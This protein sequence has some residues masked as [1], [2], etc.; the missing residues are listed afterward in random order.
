[1]NAEI[2]GLRKSVA[3][4]HMRRADLRD[5]TIL[6][7]LCRRVFERPAETAFTFV[8]DSGDEI[9]LSFA[10]L[11]ARVRRIAA[12]V[13]ELSVGAGRVLLL[14]P[15]GLEAVVAFFAAMYAKAV[16]VPAN[17]PRHARLTDRITRIAADATPGAVLTTGAIL[18]RTTPTVEP[19]TLLAGVPW[20]ATDR[21]SVSGDESLPL[22][23]VPPD[24]LAF[25]QYTSG[26]ISEPMGVM[27]RH[28]NLM[29]DQALAESASPSDGRLVMASWLPY[30]HDMGLNA[31]LRTIFTGGSAVLM[32]PAT[33]MRR[34]AR[35]LKTI[36]KFGA[37]ESGGPNF[38]FDLC[39]ETIEPD[40]MAG[41]DLSRWKTAWVGAEPVR[42]ETLMNFARH[43]LPYGFSESSFLPSYGLAEATV[44]ATGSGR[45]APRYVTVDA[46]ALSENVVRPP[47]PETRRRTVFVS[48][49]AANRAGGRVLI[50]DPSTCAPKLKNVV[51][52][53]W[54][55]GPHVAQGYWNRP[56]LS[57]KTFRARA[58]D[59][60]AGDYLRTGD[61]GFLTDDEEL[62]VTGRLK[63]L[64]IV[65]G[66]NHY[67]QDIELTAECCSSVLRKGSSAAF[68]VT[69]GG[70]ELLV[71]AIEIER[72]EMKNVDFDALGRRIANAVVRQHEV[73]VH[74]IVFLASFTIPKTSSGKIQRSATRRAYEKAELKTI[75]TWRADAQGDGDAKEVRREKPDSRRLVRQEII[76]L[77]RTSA[78][79]ALKV[80][81][82]SIGD[83]ER[84]SSIGLDSLQITSLQ[85][86]VE[87]SIGVRLPAE[88]L[89]DDPT[90]AELADEVI[91]IK[92]RDNGAPRTGVDEGR[93]PSV[94]AAPLYEK[95]RRIPQTNRVVSR[96][97]ARRLHIDG[98][99][100]V[101]FASCNYLGFDLRSDI[102]DCISEMITMW[103]VHPSWTR[104]V[105][106]PFPYFDLEE[107]LA[108]LVGARSTLVL[109]S[110]A[111][112][113][114]G[115]LP[116]LAGPDG[117]ILADSEA[118]H[119]VREACELARSRGTVLAQF[120]HN[121]LE[122]LE[123]KLKRHRDGAR[124]IIAVDGVYSMSAQYL[125]LPSYSAL[126]REF[127]A[128]LYVD[129]AHGFGVLGDAPTGERPY[130][131]GGNGIVRYHAMEYARDRIVYVA[132]LSKA[133]SSYAAFVTCSDEETKAMLQ[134]ASPYI[135]SGPIPV[136]SLASAIA[137]I[138][139]NEREGD[140]L[141]DRMY[142][143]T[144]R[145]TAAA[146]EI[147]FEVDNNAS[148]PIVFVVI[149]GVDETVRASQIAWEHGLLI[150]PGVFPAVAM[151]RGGLRF[152][153][154]AAN[155]E[156]EIE[157]AVR[158]L[159]D[160]R[161][162][163]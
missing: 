112:L 146:R 109:P 81:P 41:I 130:G 2:S 45:R 106:S 15:P 154:T 123:Q 27:I 6:D 54:I 116:R 14:Y 151:N 132:G 161:A 85:A 65:R 155:T 96:Q 89:W 99:D 28:Q 21:V 12:V 48:C 20:V 74:E 150:T 142:R 104:A 91:R 138:E 58:I 147:G 13:E 24:A 16:A 23:G 62:V 127:N 4:E 57:E 61:L 129:D 134:L 63:D 158:A 162:R 46:D 87:A 100:V 144:T 90:I 101:D 140:F 25:I 92:A 88:K 68:S 34:P 77:L 22:P 11:G 128:T 49:G 79:K 105:A 135:F 119:T 156:E 93:A 36:T 7:L 98:K 19:G 122:D 8:T 95:L 113:N 86:A 59:A 60:E 37:T 143:L 78:A 66:R 56:E 26:S 107:R 139:I 29:H 163:V 157:L 84:I 117:I 3:R 137:A 38:A 51:G 43:Y 75:G 114:I 110:I 136:A 124:V 111:L 5:E 83:A 120:R 149:G 125:D 17:P 55:S 30:F 126:A 152:S 73:S 10:E 67:P 108:R 33:F 121:D 44:F 76:R 71:V 102:K 160:I 31:I 97:S 52:E 145:L 153:V 131:R 70:P 94:A 82:D 47:G 35:W 115:V 40:E 141:R 80:A 42:Y 159:R 64:I 133:F 69:Q 9:R 50:V 118:H 39:V 32:S 72:S 53:I 18:D 1:M 148:F 103:G